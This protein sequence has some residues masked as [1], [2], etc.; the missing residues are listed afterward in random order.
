MSSILIFAAL[1]IPFKCNK[2]QFGKASYKPH[3]V[4]ISRPGVV[5]CSSW[6]IKDSIWLQLLSILLWL[7]YWVFSASL[8]SALHST[9]GAVAT[10]ALSHML[11]WDNL[12]A[13]SDTYHSRV[14]HALLNP[15]GYFKHIM[16]IIVA[17]W[18]NS[19]C[20]PLL[21]SLLRISVVV[22]Y[23]LILKSTFTISNSDFYKFICPTFNVMS[24]W[25]AP[26]FFEIKGTNPKAE[27]GTAQCSE[28]LNPLF[29]RGA[30]LLLITLLAYSE[31]KKSPVNTDFPRLVHK[32]IQLKIFRIC[33]F[34]WIL[35][36][37]LITT[38]TS[39][40]YSQVYVLLFF[41]WNIVFKQ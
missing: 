29:E 28:R 39:V 6:A 35:I 5:T 11:Y 19:F 37:Q 2:S 20:R 38:E 30:I 27:R 7:C 21:P 4:S 15:I 23:I 1:H 41:N 25:H 24:L 10:A 40:S 31:N 22:G 34:S 9:A 26:P 36:G 18:Q 32:L 8:N 14:S 3:G 12:Y 16:V 17:H 13:T 33:N